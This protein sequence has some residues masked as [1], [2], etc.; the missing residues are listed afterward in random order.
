MASA[1][2]VLSSVKLDTQGRRLFWPLVM[3]TLLFLLWGLSY[4][5][6]DVL[7]KHFQEALNIDKAKST[8]LQF[9]YFGAYAVMSWP[10]GRLME[11]YGF[12]RTVLFGL[13]LYA[14]GAFLFIPSAV[15][16]TFI[17]FL[18][19]LFVLA[20]GLC[21]IEATASPYVTLLGT[22][23]G[24]DRRIKVAQ[25]F[26][27][28]G[29]FIG[30]IIGGALFFDL[31]PSDR[32]GLHT[33]ELTYAAVGVGVLLFALIY[34]RIWMPEAK[35]VASSAVMPEASALPLLQQRHFLWAAV[36]QWLNVG[37]QI[38]L[39]AL[40]INFAVENWPGLTSANG[41]YLLSVGMAMLLAGHIVSTLLLRFMP[42]HLILTL[43]ATLNIVLTVLIA[44]DIPRVSTIALVISFF[45]CGG[46]YAYI[47]ALGMR[48]LGANA[49]RGAAALVFGVSGGAIIPPIMGLIADGFATHYSYLVLTPCYIV[50]AL[51]GWKF[52]R[53]KQVSANDDP[54]KAFRVLDKEPSL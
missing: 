6:L 25:C 50:V 12:K 49:K 14:F 39:G 36:A 34:S 22:P 54:A 7:N 28:T 53:P 2:D 46:T 33:V 16:Q 3:T 27:A 1:N 38:G 42:S 44:L 45:G 52:H 37:A 48:G 26:F 29:A 31:D 51:F 4:G 24:G 32:S 9:A 13:G 10:A 17:A 18:V 21:M 40:F 47:F 20:S 19:S 43:F 41:A 35:P 15:S 8:L 30:P 5:L 23:D 11:R